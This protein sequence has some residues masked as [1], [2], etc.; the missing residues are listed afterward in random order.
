MLII[1]FLYKVTKNC[2]H[3]T[4]PYVDNSIIY[5]YYIII[6]KKMIDIDK[7]LLELFKNEKLC[8]ECTL[9]SIIFP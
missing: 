4:I 8:I 1:K 2:K 7:K 3:I 5:R 6:E 9:Y